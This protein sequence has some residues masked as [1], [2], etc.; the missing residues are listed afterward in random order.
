MEYKMNPKIKK[1]IEEE[2]LRRFPE[3]EY[4][5][6]YFT[7]RYYFKEGAKYGYI[8]QAEKRKSEAVAFADWLKNECYN[9]HISFNTYIWRKLDDDITSYTSEEIY[10]LFLK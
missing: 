5:D 9:Y 3:D 8:Q 2:A 6:E 7:E 1:Q 10:E 4:D